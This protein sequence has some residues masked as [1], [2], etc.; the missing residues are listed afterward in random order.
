[1]KTIK[2]LWIKVWII[3]NKYQEV[4]NYLIFGALGTF[5]SIASYEICR[6][7]GLEVVVSNVISWIITVLFMY[8]TNKLF[9]FKSKTESKKK[10][11][12]EF[13]SF[14]TAR[15]ITLIIETA[16]LYVGTYILKVNDLIVKI[17]AQ[18]IIII[19]NYVFSKLI[20]FKKDKK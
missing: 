7:L 14:I 13:V 4:L 16:I 11:I 19:L 3:Y 10:L 12:K 9:V 15:I 18:I 2:N 1:M 20:I 8:V 6:L 5:V 17:I